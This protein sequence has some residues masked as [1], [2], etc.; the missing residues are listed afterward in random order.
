MMKTIEHAIKP[1][2]SVKHIDVRYIENE[3][4]DISEFEEE[5]DF[6]FLEATTP[7]GVPRRILSR[8][9]LFFEMLLPSKRGREILL[10]NAL[11]LKSK[12][13]KLRKLVELTTGLNWGDL[14]KMTKRIKVGM[15]IEEATKHE[16]SGF[17]IPK[18]TW[19]DIGGLKEVKEEIRQII[20]LYKRPDLIEKY[21]LEPPRGILLYGPPGNGKTLVGKA[22]ANEIGSRFLYFSGPEFMKKYVGETEEEIRNA[23]AKARQMRPSVLF[24]DEVEAIALRRDEHTNRIDL[25]AVS[26]FLVE[27]DGIRSNWGVFVIGTTNVIEQID[28]AVVRPGRLTPIYVSPPDKE[29][30]LEI[31][32]IKLGGKPVERSVFDELPEIAERLVGLSGAEVTNIAM[33]ALR[34]AAIR[35]IKVD[36]DVMAEAVTRATMKRKEEIL[37]SAD[38]NLKMGRD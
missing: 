8:V 3:E 22:L 2:L 31:L 20:Q 1:N 27:L 4:Y 13:K 11:G 6:V 16:L 35:G 26:Q 24:L 38:L 29:G 9:S 10:K 17:E 15:S 5:H 36:R 25:S 14:Q 34:I 33:T 21:G 23:F 32:R 37:T 28:P 19:D 12:S 7:S 18:V 30:I